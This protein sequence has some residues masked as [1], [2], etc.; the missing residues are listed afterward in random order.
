M[1]PA[2]ASG[3]IPLPPDFPE[4]A[5]A[6]ECSGHRVSAQVGPADSGPGPTGREGGQPDPLLGGGGQEP[7][8]VT[9][10]LGQIDRLSMGPVV[11]GDLI[12]L[13]LRGGQEKK[14]AWGQPLPWESWGL[15]GPHWLAQARVCLGQITA[16][17]CLFNAGNDGLFYSFPHESSPPPPF[18]VLN[19]LYVTI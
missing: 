2:F 19:H 1:A 4:E 9:P 16:W 8:N 3:F 17:D 11:A 7:G 14:A 5:A 12:S 18:Q 13:G 10:H 15:S 6:W